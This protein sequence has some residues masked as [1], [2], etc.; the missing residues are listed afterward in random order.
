MVLMLFCSEYN[1]SFA[2][3]VQPANLRKAPTTKNQDRGIEK[4]TRAS[5]FL[6]GERMAP[7]RTPAAIAN[8]RHVWKELNDICPS[9]PLTKK[10]RKK[11]GR[12]RVSDEQFIPNPLL[13]EEEQKEQKAIADLEME[14]NNG[15]TPADT[16]GVK[17]SFQPENIDME[18]DDF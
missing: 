5:D 3:R 11:G 8:R 17:K 12:P 7:W 18:G 4:N 10:S 15:S 13:S 2:N 6:D 9:Q 16:E 1:R 14:G